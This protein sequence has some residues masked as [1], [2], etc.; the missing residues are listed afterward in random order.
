SEMHLG[1][2]AR[3]G[4]IANTRDLR[5]NFAVAAWGIRKHLD[6]VSDFRFK[7]MGDDDQLKEYLTTQVFKWSNKSNF[8]QSGRFNLQ[9]ALRLIEASRFVDG[10]VFAYKLRNGRVQLIEADRVKN[11]KKDGETMPKGKSWVQGLLINDVTQRVEK[12]RIGKRDN[13]GNVSFLADVN[14]RDMLQVAYVERID[15]WR[16]ISPLLS[17]M[18]IFQDQAEASEYALAKLK[19]SQLFGIAFHRDGSE[20]MGDMMNNGT[21]LDD[22]LDPEDVNPAGYDVNLGKGPFQLDLDPGDKVD[23]LE[24]Q[25][26]SNQA[27]DYMLMMIEMALKTLDFPVNFYDE[28]KANF[29][30]SRGAMINYRKSTLSKKADLIE[31]LNSWFMWKIDWAIANGDTYLAEQKGNIQFEWVSSGFEWWDT[32]KQAKGAREMISMGLDS[33]QRIAKETGTD[34]YENIN[35]TAAA[36]KYAEEKGVDLSL[37]LV[38]PV[39]EATVEEMPEQEDRK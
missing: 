1:Q 22:I 39:E 25:N 13:S 8:D 10:D 32:L 29:A 38:G 31:F 19:I 6:Y 4:A 27:Q 21:S 26:P 17:G 3:K 33:P 9:K 37:G 12:V 20:S 16:G 30:G 23:L 11:M 35:E 15:Q 2:S 28:S 24:S 5:R 7:A 14:K 34:F 36:K 18:S